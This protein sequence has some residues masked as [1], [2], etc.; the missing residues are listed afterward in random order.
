MIYNN[1]QYTYY[2]TQI[3]NP[4]TGHRRNL[5]FHLLRPR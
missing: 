2:I 4:F 5:N 3:V 1:N